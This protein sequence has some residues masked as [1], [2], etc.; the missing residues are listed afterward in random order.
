MHTG[1]W[2]FVGPSAKKALIEGIEL[3]Q[4]NVFLELINSCILLCIHWAVPS[5]GTVQ[6]TYVS[7]GWLIYAICDCMMEV[8]RYFVTVPGSSYQ[9]NWD[10]YERIIMK[11]R[12]G[13]PLWFL[14]P[15]FILMRPWMVSFNSPSPLPPSLSFVIKVSFRFFAFKIFLVVFLWGGR[16]KWLISECLTPFSHDC[17]KFS[18]F[19][20]CHQMY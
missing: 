12:F 6:W 8:T 10:Y 2:A 1:G 18:G 13:S 20:I 11:Y 15:H 4:A 9:G 19:I 16:L 7:D 3:N 5:E 17:L 14:P